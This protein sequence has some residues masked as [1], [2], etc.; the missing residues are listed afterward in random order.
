[1]QLLTIGNP[2]QSLD[3]EDTEGN[4]RENLRTA[5]YTHAQIAEYV[6]FFRRIL[7]N[8]VDFNLAAV[9]YSKIISA[10]TNQ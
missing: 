2:V 1:M 9:K 3:V 10:I 8:K 4:G 7:P 5:K 6:K